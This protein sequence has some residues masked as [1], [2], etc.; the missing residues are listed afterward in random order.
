MTQIFE[1]C[2]CKLLF[3]Q[4]H[5]WQQPTALLIYINMYI[6]IDISTSIS[7]VFSRM[8]WED[9][10]HK[11]LKYV[12]DASLLAN[13]YRYIRVRTNV[14]MF[15]YMHTLACRCILSELNTK[16]TFHFT[17]T[18]RIIKFVDTPKLISVCL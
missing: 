11:L 9:S 16:F 3:L 4:P 1:K 7:V 12:M 14:F 18:L 17:V 6:C 2:I 15:T 10:W 5:I 13:T 8:R